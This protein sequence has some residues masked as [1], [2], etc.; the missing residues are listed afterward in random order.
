MRQDDTTLIRGQES[1]LST[2][3]VLKNTYWLLSL[4]LLFSA[5][6]AG[7]AMALNVQHLGFFVTLIGMFGLLFLTQALAHSKWGLLAVFAFTGFMGFTLGPTLNLY[8]QT[9][10]NGSELIMTALGGTG[11]IFLALSAYV[12]NTQKDFS[13]MGGFLMVAITVVILA[14]IAN[15]FFCHASIA[16]LFICCNGFD[17]FRFLFYLKP[18]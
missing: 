4:T 16:S 3:K 7:L 14:S 9:F 13:Y 6:S 1:V 17:F 11:I 2:N 12:M 10:S 5:A 18:V 15:F 8:I